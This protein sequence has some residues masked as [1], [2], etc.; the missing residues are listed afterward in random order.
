MPPAARR[1]LTWTIAA[2]VL[3]SAQAPAL[4]QYTW[5]DAKGQLHASDQPPP[6]DVPDKDIIR[7]PA[8]RTAT[9]LAAATA[10]S[11][12]A[13]AAPSRNA[14]ASAPVDPELQQRRARAEQEAKAK[15]QAEEQRLA[16]QRAENCQRARTHLATLDSGTRLVR[17]DARGERVVV[18]DATRA[19]EAAEARG[20]ITSD[21]R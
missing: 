8:A 9:A 1:L 10:A 2:L 7:R 13:S 15:A 3:A 12:A 5:R 14:A 20:V 11:G 17:V 19:R 6:R 4:A 21:C 16:S 18:D